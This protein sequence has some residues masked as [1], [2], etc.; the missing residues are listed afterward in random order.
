[1]PLY[2]HAITCKVCRRVLWLSHS[3]EE[4]I[5]S[6]QVVGL[7]LNLV[8]EEDD[9]EGLYMRRGL[10]SETRGKWLVG[11]CCGNLPHLRCK[12]HTELKE[13]EKQVSEEV[14]CCVGER[15]RV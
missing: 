9:E 14:C 2:S 7:Q 10:H 8:E 3:A 1:M 11:R 13:P 6:C 15:G 4:S 5:L 12:F